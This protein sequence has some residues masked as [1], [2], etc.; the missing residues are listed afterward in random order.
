VLPNASVEE[1]IAEVQKQA[2]EPLEEA[3]YYVMYQNSKVAFAPWNPSPYQL[4]SSC[5]LATTI[6]VK[7]RSGDLTVQVPTC[8]EERW[9]DIAYGAIPDPPLTLHQ[10][11]PGVFTAFYADQIATMKARFVR[12]DLGEEH[13]V[14]MLP[15]WEDQVIRVWEAFG[16]DM[17]PDEAQLREDGVIFVK[18][19]DRSPQTQSLR[20]SWHTLWEKT[21]RNTKSEFEEA[22]PRRRSEKV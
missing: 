20:E 3:R 4:K 5:L 17:I 1:I 11:E 10:T 18:S 9:Q 6:L 12:E 14:N 8:H 15:M 16:R 21:R 22:T 7:Y 13:E 2:D 19:A